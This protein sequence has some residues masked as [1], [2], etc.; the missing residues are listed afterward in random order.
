MI[1][2]YWEKHHLLSTL[3]VLSGNHLKETEN[4]LHFMQYVKPDS[5]VLE[6]GVGFGYCLHELQL[7][8]PKANLYALD[9]TEHAIDKVRDVIFTGWTDA[10]KV[11]INS[12]DCIYSLLV[13]PHV[14]NKEFNRM[15]KHLIAGLRP[16]GTLV[17][18]TCVFIEPTDMDDSDGACSAGLALRNINYV[19]ESI[20]NNGGNPESYYVY[21]ELPHLN[22]K[23]AVFTVTKKEGI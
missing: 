16:T 20:V 1:K 14:N 5:K 3:G 15:L 8:Y 19:V 10:A 9:I 2:E 4:I 17:F 21:E 13:F 6:V 11:P 12:F 18:Q 23:G 22:M 7:A